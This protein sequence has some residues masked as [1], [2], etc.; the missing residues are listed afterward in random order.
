MRTKGAWNERDLETACAE[1]KALVERIGTEGGREML[2]A[3]ASIALGS[4]LHESGQWAASTAELQRALGVCRRLGLRNCSVAI[5]GAECLRLQS[6]NQRCMGQSL[7]A[8]RMAVEAVKIAE[9]AVLKDS[10][11][12]SDQVVRCKEALARAYCE[13]GQQAKALEVWEQV[14]A[15]SGNVLEEGDDTK[16][17]ALADTLAWMVRTLGNLNMHSVAEAKLLQL[18]QLRGHVW[19]ATH[20][21]TIE[22]LLQL[23]ACVGA[24]R[25]GDEA[26]QIYKAVMEVEEAQHGSHHPMVAICA[27][28]IASQSDAISE[29][30]ELGMAVAQQALEI[31]A[32][33]HPAGHPFITE[34]LRVQGSLCDRLA[35]PVEAARAWKRAM[36]N[37][38]IGESRTL[39]TA[40]MVLMKEL[41]QRYATSLNASNQLGRGA[42]MS[43][44]VLDRPGDHEAQHQ[45]S[46]WGRQSLGGQ[47]RASVPAYLNNWQVA[48]A[49]AQGPVQEKSSPESPDFEAQLQKWRL[50]SG[51]MQMQRT[52]HG[53]QALTPVVL[54]DQCQGSFGSV[55]AACGAPSSLPSFIPRL[56]RQAHLGD[57]RI[58]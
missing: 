11:A 37:L 28:H 14:V 18:V 31:A 52:D 50:G 35:Q 19:G 47:S 10:M 41:Q 24:Q 48:A 33:S 22:V 8:Q 32:R 17:L 44:V 58:T 29:E 39:D 16:V 34:I 15:L 57:S 12:G 9:S 55:T 20:H 1:A 21:C 49:G 53:R 45:T 7:E 40:E 4:L 54:T 30:L 36:K 42:L 13:L 46:H 25:R 43:S 51:G 2:L 38:V 5:H 56:S 26:L 23:G 6:H 27:F 3:V